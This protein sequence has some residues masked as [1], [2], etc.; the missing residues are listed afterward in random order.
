VHKG[1]IIGIKI[2]SVEFQEKGFTPEEAK[3]LCQA[4]ETA[5]FDYVELS[6]GTYQSL[7]FNHKRESTKKT[8]S[9]FLE[10][11]EDIVKPLTKTKTYITGGFK[12]VGAMVKALETVDGVGLA[13]PVCQEPNLPREILESK[14]SGAIQ[15][16][17]DQDNFSLTNI[18][19]GTQIRQVGKD[20]EPVDFSEQKNVDGS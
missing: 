5:R 15:Q 16:K 9:F 19:A 3:G 12:T 20:Q 1:F 4:L 7:A 2:N 11:A 10:F 14:V 8:E 18:A 13:R 6:G 17:L